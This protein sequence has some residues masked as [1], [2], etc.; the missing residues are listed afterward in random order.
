MI[1]WG[2]FSCLQPEWRISGWSAS[3]QSKRRSGASAEPRRWR[4][5]VP[6]TGRRVP[7]SRT[8]TPPIRI[9]RRDSLILSRATGSDLSRSQFISGRAGRIF[10]ARKRPL[11]SQPTGTWQKICDR[12]R[13]LA[14][15][16]VASHRHR[17]QQR[18]GRGC[19]G[20]RCRRA[21][22]TTLVTP[23]RA[24]SGRRLPE[25]D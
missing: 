17:D 8:P 2:A 22:G 13:A 5:R 25:A 20:C 3:G 23:A 7:R 9:A 1:A 24:R 11:P 18:P 6:W 19:A 14:K 16:G 10:P 21:A 12:G 15:S 4:W